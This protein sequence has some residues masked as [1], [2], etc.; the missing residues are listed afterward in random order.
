MVGR[1][2]GGD[3]SKRPNDTRMGLGGSRY[4]SVMNERGL[5][6]Y[7]RCR[8]LCNIIMILAL[9]SVSSDDETARWHSTTESMYLKNTFCPFQESTST[10]EDS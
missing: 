8:I 9:S 1:Q 7:F 2:G 5:G 3:G 6:V 10:T 4:R